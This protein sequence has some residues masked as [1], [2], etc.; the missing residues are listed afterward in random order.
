MGLYERIDG[1][2]GL[3]RQGT[4]FTNEAHGALI[5]FLSVIYMMSVVPSILSEAGMN[6]EQTFT[7]TV[8]I[9]IIGCLL[10]GLYANYPMCQGP[11]LGLCTFFT[12][13][14]VKGMGY[15]WQ[16]ALAAMFVSSVIFVFVSFTG[17]RQKILDSMPPGIRIS[18]GMGVGA[19]IAYVGLV[20]SGILLRDP[21]TIFAIG[22]LT[23]TFVITAIFC[24]I[25]TLVLHF[26]KVKSAVFL[27]MAAAIIFGLIIGSVTL[28]ENFVETPVMPDMFAFIHGFDEG[29]FNLQ[30]VGII[31]CLAVMQFFEG[32]A[33]IF[34]V[35][36]VLEEQD[37]DN[38]IN[39]ALKADSAAAAASSIVDISPTVPYVESA[40]G[41]TAGSRT[42][43]TAVLIA[44]LMAFALFLG[45]LFMV[46]GY[47]CTVGAMFIIGISTMAGFRKL[48]RHD[49]PTILA[50]VT[51][52]VTMIVSYSIAIGLSLGF[53]VYFASVV[54]SGRRK[55]M[56]PLMYVLTIILGAYF[57]LEFFL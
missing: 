42:G 38:D 49:I 35:S 41:V 44:I 40:V 29:F 28:P 56:G 54:L 33:S 52:V 3:T 31:F 13:T 19:Y 50:A 34:A 17:I 18:I 51:M 45:P 23:S 46:I 6:V 16:E 27:G 24:I 12:Y 25:V 48:D 8:I 36:D 5:T 30:M 4:K 43:L 39:R 20:N 15:T 22:D 26:L 10:M 47:Q 7:A 53:V 11:A 55:E 9:T 14:I 1:F 57:V 32:T 37:N 2:F 21:V